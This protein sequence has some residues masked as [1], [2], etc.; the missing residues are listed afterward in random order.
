MDY[1][2]PFEKRLKVNISV[3][4]P[5]IH[6]SIALRRCSMESSPSGQPPLATSLQSTCR[7]WTSIVRVENAAPI[8]GNEVSGHQGISG[9]LGLKQNASVRTSML[10]NAAVILVKEVI[11][12]HRQRFQFRECEQKACEG[13]QGVPSVLRGDSAACREV[14]M[15]ELYHQRKLKEYGGLGRQ[16]RGGASHPWNHA[17]PKFAGGKGRKQRIQPAER[18]PTEHRRWG[19]DRAPARLTVGSEVTVWRALFSSHESRRQYPVELLVAKSRMYG[20]RR[21][22]RARA[23]EAARNVGCRGDLSCSD[24]KIPR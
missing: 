21:G 10:G 22:N 16:P 5:G 11:D 20:L 17:Q 14:K 18:K 2:N 12:G 19:P 15:N 13:S 7:R 1:W 9:S 3:G 4:T 8:R 23:A 24:R 6:C